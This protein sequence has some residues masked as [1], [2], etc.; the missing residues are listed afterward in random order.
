MECPSNMFTFPAQMYFKVILTTIYFNHGQMK[1]CLSHSICN[2]ELFDMTCFSV[3]YKNQFWMN[4]LELMD[5]LSAPKSP[6]HGQP[7]FRSE[8]KINK[9]QN[10]MKW[11][12]CVLFLPVHWAHF[13]QYIHSITSSIPDGWKWKIVCARGSK[14]TENR[15][16][17]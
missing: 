3:L 1:V 12:C 14:M 7:T 5:H 13:V 10:T 16:T 15:T 9:T 6:L 4:I 2:S 8:R 11:V 17:L